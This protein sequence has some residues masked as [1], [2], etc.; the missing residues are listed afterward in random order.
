MIERIF[1]TYDIRGVYPDAVNEDAAWKI[2]YATALYLQRSR[3]TGF[4]AKVALEK[5]IVVGRDSRP[6]S[7][8]LA[9]ALIEGI[10]AAGTDVIDVG[11]VDSPL[12]Y[13][14]V[15]HLDC[16]AGI[17]VTASHNNVEYNGFK[18]SGPKARPI[19]AATG[20]EDIRRI[21]GTLRVGRTGLQGNLEQQD[22]WAGYR[23]HV[24]QHLQLKR[25]VRVAVDA[26]N[27]MAGWMVP[28]VFD[29]VPDIEIIPLCFETNGTFAHSPNP[30][31]DESMVALR[32]KVLA[33]KPDLGV[34][35]DG[36]ADRCVC[37][38]ELG[39]V[40]RPDLVAAII[41]RDYLS[42]PANAKATIVYDL[43]CS[44]VLSEE[45]AAAGGKPHRERVGKPFIKRTMSDTGAI[46]G[47]ESSGHFYFRDNY[48][49]DSG[50][51]AFARILSI[52]SASSIP[53]SDMIKPLNRYAHSGE[54]TFA[55]DDGSI[56]IRD[57]ADKYRKA[58][59]DYI[60]GITLDLG[61]WWFNVRRSNTEPVLRLNMECANAEMLAEKLQEV[62]T[63]ITEPVHT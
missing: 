56:K 19:S 27:G 52:V 30:L 26:S 60:D 37:M 32:E 8:A 14:A 25:K 53:F 12:I 23:R 24:L 9:G 3:Q 33:D 16:V 55:S 48:C 59:I 17:E 41:A 1:K 43:R 18:I 61:D 39:N 29:K 5:A 40:I 11:M 4:G 38:D 21:S 63:L 22:L 28:A 49:A 58:K 54:L 50:A 57:L 20:L 34:C 51:I 35:F 46:F 47:A 15:N 13:Y 42:S 44:R 36:D 7:P 31:L 10:R 2:G 62:R 45:I 6:H